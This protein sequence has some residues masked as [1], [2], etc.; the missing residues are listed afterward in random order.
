MNSIKPPVM[1]TRWVGLQT[2]LRDLAFV[3]DRQG[4]H[5][6]ADLACAVAARIDELLSGP[7]GSEAA[8]SAAALAVRSPA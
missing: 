3:L 2:E 8:A 4:S 6:A 7:G 1:D 5:E